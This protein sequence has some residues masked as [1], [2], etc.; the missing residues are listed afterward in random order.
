MNTDYVRSSNDGEEEEKI[1]WQQP[2]VDGY[3]RRQIEVA[4]GVLAIFWQ[5][6]YGVEEYSPD[7][8]YY[9]HHCLYLG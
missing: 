5:N 6:D 8:L 3:W 4:C 7:G 1:L 9:L 2:P